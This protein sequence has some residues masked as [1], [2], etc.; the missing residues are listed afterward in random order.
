[1]SGLRYGFHHG[2]VSV[3][4]LD[5]A[6]AWYGRV[7]GFSLERRFEIPTIPA[8]VAMIAN[9]DLRIELFEVPGAA[10][11][12][13]ERRIPDRDVHTH[14]VKHVAFVTPDVA[15]LVEELGGRGADIVWLKVMPHGT[16]CF[17]R[18]LAGNLIE[19]VQ[20][21]VPAGEAGSL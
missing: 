9:G 17:I 20:G 3:P 6:V 10:P 14:G 4:D 1:M 13:D 2:G 15:A 21:A 8:Q 18:D 16:A 5:A 19:F 12:P 7:L 11:L